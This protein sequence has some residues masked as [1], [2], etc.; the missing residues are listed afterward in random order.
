[1]NAAVSHPNRKDPLVLRRLLRARDRMDGAPDEQW[2]VSKLARVSGISE[3]HFAR[4]FKEAFGI[5]PHRYL[6]TR[7]V[8][9]A[10]ALLRDTD[11]PSPRS[12]SRSAGIAWARSRVPFGMLRGKRPVNHGERRRH[13]CMRSNM[14]PTASS[15]RRTGQTSKSQFRRSDGSRRAV[16]M[17]RKQRRSHD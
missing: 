3:A 15:A 16:L 4:S 13:S 2:P 6:L 9:R 7:R 10:K 11:R 17:R 1:M 12:L 8:E 14:C 5:P